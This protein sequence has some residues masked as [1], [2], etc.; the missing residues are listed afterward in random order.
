MTAAQAASDFVSVYIRQVDIQKDQVYRLVFRYLD[1][2]QSVLGRKHTIA[3]RLQRSL[4]EPHIIR[5]IFN[6]KNIVV[7]IHSPY[8]TLFSSITCT[9]WSTNLRG[10]I[11]PF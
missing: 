10:G 6:I 9:T 11:D 1:A 2:I 8:S 3:S 7:L 5:I 4:D